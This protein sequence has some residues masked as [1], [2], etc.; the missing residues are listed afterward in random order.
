MQREPQDAEKLPKGRQGKTPSTNKIDQNS[1]QRFFQLFIKGFADGGNVNIK[2][3]EFLV[4][5][6]QQHEVCS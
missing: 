4:T 5:N 3:Q 1:I 6:E 2:G